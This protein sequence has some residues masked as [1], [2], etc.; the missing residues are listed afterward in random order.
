MTRSWV[1]KLLK[2]AFQRA[3]IGGITLDPLF[4]N[5]FSNISTGNFLTDTVHTHHMRLALEQIEG[6]ARTFDIT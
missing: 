4:G 2:L 5:R 1:A 6:R 3:W